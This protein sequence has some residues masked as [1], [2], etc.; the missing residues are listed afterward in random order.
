MHLFTKAKFIVFI[1]AL[2]GLALISSFESNQ[3][4]NETIIIEQGNNVP[5]KE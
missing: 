4:N 1:V 3:L 5:E 2:L